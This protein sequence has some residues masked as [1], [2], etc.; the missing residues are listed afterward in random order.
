MS[1]YKNI[2]KSNPSGLVGALT[3]LELLF[4]D[5]ATRPSLRWLR[6]QQAKRLIPYLKIGRLVFFDPVQVRLAFDSQF[7]VES[8]GLSMDREAASTMSLTDLVR[9]RESNTNQEQ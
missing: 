8:I 5:E 4:P 3:L 1:E 7:K 9:V 6:H 2:T